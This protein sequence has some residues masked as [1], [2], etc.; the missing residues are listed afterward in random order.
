MTSPSAVRRAGLTVCAAGALLLAAG[1]SAAVES[2][3]APSSSAASSA[4]SSSASAF[5]A[6]TTAEP[7]PTTTSEASPEA[8][9]EATP[10]ALPASDPVGI[11]VP[12]IGVESELMDLGLQDNG[13]IEVPP[14]NL[15]SPAGWYVHSPT[16]GET[17]PAVILGHR[18]GIEGGPGIFADLPQVEVGDSIEVARQDG[19]EAS[20]TVYRTERFGKDREGFPTLE[21]YGNTAGPELRLI[22][23]DG[24]N[25]QTGLLEENFIVYATLDS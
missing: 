13:M 5:P 24:L 10:V 1:C 16:P 20:F 14:Y 7:E 9:A 2:P 12:G 11:S 15:G 4:A 22:T 19:S 17:G 6:E 25:E 3:S 23:C 8:T 18:N 21:V